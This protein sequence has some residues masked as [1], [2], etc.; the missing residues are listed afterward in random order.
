MQTW[1]HQAAT[2]WVRVAKA[3]AIATLCL[4]PLR[5]HEGIDQGGVLEPKSEMASLSTLGVLG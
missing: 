1:V 3:L 5:V 2:R 4:S